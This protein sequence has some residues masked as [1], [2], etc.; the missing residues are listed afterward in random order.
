MKRTLLLFIILV[1]YTSSAFSSARCT[2]PDPQTKAGI[3]LIDGGESVGSGV[4]V[5]HNQILTAAHVIKG[6]DTIYVQVNGAL[7]PAHVLSEDSTKDLA[8]LR[9]DTGE[10][11]PLVLSHD[12]LER[13]DDVWAM[14]YPFGES[15]VSASGRYRGTWDNAIYTSASVNFG[16]SGGGLISC[17]RGKPV[18]A[19]MVRAFG[20]VKKNGKLV[21]R[22]DISVAVRIE[23]IKQFL[24][25]SRQVA[26]VFK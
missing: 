16:Q 19:G 22:D 8:L 26:S 13:N 23:T 20:A 9:A 2:S 6:M 14:G 24:V 3:V 25:T 18:L 1:F 4:V 10:T 21:R 7:V 11:V 5:A 15:L 12:K 17:E